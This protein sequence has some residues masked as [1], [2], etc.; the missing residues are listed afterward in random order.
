MIKRHSNLLL[1]VTVIFIA[2]TLGFFTGRNYNPSPVQIQHLPAQSAPSERSNDLIMQAPM[3]TESITEA[4]EETQIATV[5][6]TETAVHTEPEDS[7]IAVTEAATEPTQKADPAP[8]EAPAEVPEETKA[9]PEKKDTQKADAPSSGLI[10]I[11]TASASQLMTLPGIGEVLAQRI[12]DYREAYGP[13]PSVAALTN[14]KGIGEKRLAAI[15]NL[16]TV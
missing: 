3:E 13:F 12:V 10:N 14:V 5:P 2:F 16:V 9:K 1:L 6:E 15:M 8:T 4:P 7:E 11:N